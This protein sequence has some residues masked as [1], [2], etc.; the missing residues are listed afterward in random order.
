MKK[1][2]TLIELLVVIAIIAILAAMLLPALSASR[3]RARSSSCTGNLKQI[4]LAATMYRD[5][6]S[7][8]FLPTNNANP[9]TSSCPGGAYHGLNLLAAYFEELKN[10]GSFRFYK[11]D[12]TWMQKKKFRFF[13]CASGAGEGGAMS[14]SWNYVMSWSLTYGWGDS[15]LSIRT[16]RGL[17]NVLASS[18]N[19]SSYT[20]AKSAEDVWWFADGDSSTGKSW[21]GK[22]ST[23][24]VSGT[25]HN[26]IANFLTV[27]GSVLNGK[28]EANYGNS[29]K[30]GYALPTK[31]WVYHDR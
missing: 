21:V 5:D 2:F 18:E 11:E 8:W 14:D 12:L 4:G 28:A 22:G 6:N 19:K 20:Y 31:Y 23:K 9:S 7:D 30:Y 16:F 24:N 17:E 3:E 26:G 15:Y 27:T 29:T 10:T 25:R 1:H 13:V